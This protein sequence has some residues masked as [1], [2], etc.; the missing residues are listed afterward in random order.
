MACDYYI[1]E[2]KYTEQ[3]FKKLLS[4][5]K[6]D[7]FISD[8]SI[9]VGNLKSVPTIIPP[10]PPTPPVSENTFMYEGSKKQRE[11]GLLNHLVNAEKVPE[12]FKNGLKE[13]GL[14]YE[15]SNQYEASESAK[16]IIASI[17]RNDAIEAART[18]MIDPSVGSAIYG[19][20]LNDIFKE[21]QA[22]RLEGK[23]KEADVLAKEW[24]D[25]SYEYAQLSNK[26]GKWNAQIAYFYKSSP[27]GVVMRINSDRS[28]QFKEW[29]KNREEGYKEVFDEIIKSEEGQVLLKEE[30]EKLRKEERKGERKKR[31]KDITDFFE[32]AK[33][34]GGTYAT[35]I[36]PPI[37]N[38]AIDIMAASV[39]AGDRVVVAVQKAI[40]YID[41]NLKEDWDKEAF[42]KEYESKI[43]QVADGSKK[44]KSET[45]LLQARIKSLETQIA[46]YNKLIEEGGGRKN[47]PKEEQFKDNEK[48]AELVKERD[49]LRKENEKLVRKSTVSPK[50]NS[51]EALQKRIEKLEEELERVTFRRSKEKVEKGTT[52]DKE[53]TQREKELKEAISK[54]NEKWDAEIDNARGVA[55]D[56]QKLETERNRQLKRVTDLKDKL[57]ILLS[58]ELPETKKNEARAD[59]PEIESLKSEIKIAEKY[60]RESI[61]HEN[62]LKR[63]EK[64]LDRLK[65]RKKREKNTD[66]K[67]EITEDESAIRQ[68]I[69]A[70]RLA[71]KIEDNIGKLN[72]ELER[73]KNRK[74]KETEPNNKRKLTNEEQSIKDKIKQENEM[75]AKEL[76]P[77]R[78]AAAEI[79][80]KNS[81]I[82][83]LNRRIQESD[84][85]KE[86]YQAK[87]EKTELDKELDKVKESYNE[88]RKTS[89]EYIDKKAKQYLNSLRK[90][91][92][93]LNEKQKE[94]I[95]RRSIKK[96]TES[97][98][99]QYE[100]FKD[101]VS[102]VM[103]IKKLSD[104]DVKRIEELTEQANSV[105]QKELDF[106]NTPTKENLVAFKKAKEQSLQA[107]R[108]L[109]ELTHN[110]ADIVGTLKS[111][112]TLNLLSLPTL[113]KNYDQNVI[114]QAVVRFP[115]SVV[116]T[117]SEKAAYYSS[118]LANRFFGTKIFKPTVELTAAQKGYFKEYNKGI[119]RGWIQMIKGVDEKD[120]FAK[121]QYAS[122]LNP[123]KSLRDLKSYIKGDLYLTTA[124]KIDK[125]IQA[126]LGWQPYAIS[127]GMIYGDKPPRYA[128][129][130]AAALQIAHTEL[131]ISDPIQMEA[132]ILSPEKYSYNHYVKAGMDSKKAGELS[133]GIS[134]RIVSAGAKATFQNENYLNDLLSKID[135]FAKITD[136]DR[137]GAKIVKPTIA[138]GKAFTLPFIKTPAN[139]MWAYFKMANP[140][141]TLAKSIGEHA[142]ANDRRKKGDIVGY[143]EYQKKSK[144]SF[145]MSAIGYGFT[146]AAVTLAQ[147]GLIRT[148]HDE[149]DKARESA[150]EAFFGKNNQLNLGKLLGVDD[151]WVDLSWFS[152]IGTILDTQARIIEDKRAKGETDFKYN[153]ADDFL[154]TLTYSAAASLNTLVFDQ[155]AKTIDAIRKGGNYFDYWSTQTFNTFSNIFTGGT[156]PSIS[157]ALLPE[158]ANLKADNLVDQIINNQ[159]QRNIFIRWAAGYPPSKI[160]M[161]GDP[162]KND[163]SI[164]GVIG[165][166]LGFELTHSNKFGAIL[167]DDQQRTGLNEFFPPV[168]DYK[169]KVDGK[170]VKITTEEKNDLDIFIGQQ[171]KALLSPFLYDKLEIPGYDKRYSDMKDKEKIDAL[172]V[173]YDIGK[174]SGFLKFKEKYKQY[175]DSEL[176]VNKMV[177]EIKSGIK[178]DVLKLSLEY[179]N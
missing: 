7:E 40:E 170:D 138:L 97:G 178:K 111:I 102:D 20:S 77:A 165:Q 35:I 13:K 99:L 127:R 101:I 14:Q 177:E 28:G 120:Y 139:I 149:D 146:L 118:V 89:Q 69:E 155:G 117:V 34:K 147:K 142:Y 95:V 53:I 124:Q 90:R 113:V 62:K 65:E 26:K 104:K 109:F 22:L 57:D 68:E 56:Y 18:E 58:G 105:D 38:G 137:V 81:A 163:N 8:E 143:R 42:R 167:Y 82:K 174:K 166:M 173:I 179:K 50:T 121:N 75:W 2:N 78:K 41:K 37:W 16:G 156:L 92:S 17:G 162:I 76:E 33:M 4:E 148:S 129:Q 151:M 168:E 32:K 23:N 161:W 114:Y 86:A 157:K 64:E 141:L 45:E 85:S 52:K 70:E 30:V 9:N 126:T 116:I 91:L 71:W 59:T 176:D 108:E 133:K 122:P 12:G 115:S 172:K 36:P 84:Y 67:K 128:A 43:G 72:E 88:A 93:G 112:A 164:K 6:L 10:V 49:R 152:A 15:V 145:A 107:D 98:G 48:V 131:N 144:E 132:F 106:L 80:R 87:K 3:E 79:K 94:D 130:G 66:D 171:R 96:I 123:S 55:K 134:D 19:E 54:E 25:T 47:K 159:K 73:V 27:M 135:D 153:L 11:Y 100:E 119:I 5:G 169:I 150:G 60:V 160:S 83:E 21:E 74:E 44:E 175:Q 51:E 154:S 63:L 140:T 125:G 39:K 61:S 158:K 1:G 136:K 29:F 103:G 31:D 24:A 110:E 46:D